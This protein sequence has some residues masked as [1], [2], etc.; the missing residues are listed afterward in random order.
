MLTAGLFS[1]QLVLLRTLPNVSKL[2][3]SLLN[4]QDLFSPGR[5]A[6]KQDRER[7][8]RPFFSLLRLR[9]CLSSLLPF[10]VSFFPVNNCSVLS[11]LPFSSPVAVNNC[12]T[13][14]YAFRSRT[15][16]CD[17]E[18]DEIKDWEIGER[19]TIDVTG[20]VDGWGSTH[21]PN[22]RLKERK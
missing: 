20:N 3:S 9:P 5:G 2:L 12:S 15:V 11:L 10:Y 8:Q 4:E 7:R 13:I 1:H 16:H 6:Q 22:S 21:P 18:G 14:C 17:R 19:I